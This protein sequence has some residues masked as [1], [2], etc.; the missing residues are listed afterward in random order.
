MKLAR[1]PVIFV[2]PFIAFITTA[3]AAQP[4]SPAT[5]ENLRTLEKVQTLRSEGKRNE[6]YALAVAT[7]GRVREQIG[8][9]QV[10][11]QVLTELT[12]IRKEIKVGRHEQSFSASGL[13]GWVGWLPIFASF[14]NTLSYDI[15]EIVVQNPR[16]VAQFPV[17]IQ[18]DLKALRA[19]LVA[20]IQDHTLD[21]VVLKT[22][23]VSYYQML[24]EK[25]GEGQSFDTVELGEVMRASL[26]F[27]F[28]GEQTVNA[29]VQT[30]YIDSSRKSSSSGSLSLLGIFNLIGASESRVDRKFAHQVTECKTEVNRIEAT[31]KDLA[32]NVNLTE[33]DR[34][35]TDWAK[36]AVLKV[37]LSSG[38]DEIF[39]V[40]GSPYFGN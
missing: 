14:E 16:E 5:L 38:N 25:A 1:Y 9:D 12:E 19:M 28:L 4:P 32:W 39:P 34:V 29:C 10:V 36:A 18:N 26:Q 8:V 20:Y 15:T 33:L 13:W 23:A 22:L 3:S 21:L 31:K 30:D 37:S 27:H 17:K 2:L 35:T 7:I 40:F 24:I 6:A 11:V